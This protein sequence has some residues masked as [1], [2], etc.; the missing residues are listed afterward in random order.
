[1]LHNYFIITPCKNE[2]RNLPKLIESIVSQTV[3]PILWVILDD[4]STDNTPLIIK[5]AQ[6]KYNWIKYIQ[7]TG[8]KR[9]RGIHLSEVIK[10]GF[11]YATAFCEKNRLI[12]NYMGNIDG[13]LT[14]TTT[15]LENLIR[16]FKKNPKLGIASGGTNNIINNK[17]IH[18]KISANE[19]SGGHMLIRKECYIACGGIPL[20]RAVDSV[21]KAKARLRGWE[22]RRFEENIAIE[23]RDVGAAEGY[24]KGYFESGKAHYFINMNPFH[25]FFRGIKYLYKKH[26]ISGVA[27]ISG[28]F[29]E[30]IRQKEQIDDNEVKNYFWNK[31]KTKI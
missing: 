13:D 20:S 4:G 19:P 29:N 25:V 10:M 12:Y 3:R 17:I 15:F 22:T 23:I 30:M 14:L 1:M 28:Y 31:W 11:D 26:N 27:Y 7:T 24:W 16:E 6:D 9:D 2:E 8:I 21:L 18:A 5:K